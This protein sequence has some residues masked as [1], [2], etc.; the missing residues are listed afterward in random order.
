MPYLSVDE[1]EDATVAQPQELK[2]KSQADHEG[3]SEED[4]DE[5]GCDTLEEIL[6]VLH[7]Y[8]ITSTQLH[9]R[10]I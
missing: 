5:S 7:V 8:I 3:L 9:T 10:V 4:D 2:G 1:C 6:D